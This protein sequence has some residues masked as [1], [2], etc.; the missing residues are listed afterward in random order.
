VAD[1]A[2]GFAASR[3]VNAEQ[4]VR[5]AQ[6]HAGLL[7]RAGLGGRNLLDGEG[8]PSQLNTVS[9]GSPTAVP[10]GERDQH[11]A[12][13]VRGWLNFGRVGYIVS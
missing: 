9:H 2:W 1:G 10:A 8:E 11:R 12:E 3:D 13:W 4:V 7:E 5:V 6:Q